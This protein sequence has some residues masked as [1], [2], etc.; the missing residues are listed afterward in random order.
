MRAE[1]GLAYD[2]IAD[3]YERGRTAWPTAICDGVEGS[4]VLDLAAGTGKLT[5]VLTP[6]FTR[7]LAVEPLDAMRAVGERIVPEAD[8]RRGTAEEIPVEDTSVDAVFVADAFHWFDAHRAV[9]ELTRVLKVGGTLVVA[10]A[11]WNGTWRPSL[12]RTALEAIDEVSRRTGE[13]G[14]PRIERGEWMRAFEGSAFGVFDERDVPFVHEATRADVIAYYLSMSTVAARPTGERQALAAVLR[15]HIPDQ[16]HR[17]DLRARTF[18]AWKTRPD[19]S[20]I[21]QVDLYPR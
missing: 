19:A 12:P 4:V 1:Q 9:A 11:A 10:F 20:A 21:A 3:D 14:A 13:T 18:R 6:R 15:E 8:W 5:R 16:R 2:P 17:L 7:V